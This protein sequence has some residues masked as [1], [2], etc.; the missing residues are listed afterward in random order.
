MRATTG[1]RFTLCLS[2]SAMFAGCAATGST[3]RDARSGGNGTSFLPVPETFAQDLAR[4]QRL[5][6]EIY[7]RDRAAE[8]T[9]DALFPVAL[10]GQSNEKRSGWVVT[11]IGEHAYRVSYLVLVDGTRRVDAE[12]D[13][14]AL[15]GKVSNLR[16]HQPARDLDTAELA[17]ATAI[18]QALRA[19]VLR[20]S[21]N[22]NVVALPDVHDAIDVYLIPARTSM[23]VFPM[24]GFHRITLDATGENVRGQYAQTKTCI[25]M[26]RETGKGKPVGLFVTHLT[27]AAPT[28]LHVFMSLNYRESIYVITVENHMLWSVSGDTVHLLDTDIGKR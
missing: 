21:A 24:G 20:C 27:T 2:L 16:S 9:T 22:Y 15:T 1:L 18:Q 5:G 17:Q 26:Q 25:D 6:R 19:E 10:R 11:A 4:A 7:E 8:L 12:A 23:D 3:S 14:S 28:A 13:Y